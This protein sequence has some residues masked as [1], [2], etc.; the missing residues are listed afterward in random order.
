MKTL[1]TFVV[2]L[3]ATASAHAFT[4]M[5]TN[6]YGTNI[7]ATTIALNGLASKIQSMEQSRYFYQGKIDTLEHQVNRMETTMLILVCLFVI[8]AVAYCMLKARD[9]VRAV[10]A[11]DVVA[12]R[13]TPDDAEK[14]KE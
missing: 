10:R 3:L 6:T 5:P 2:L 12:R 8:V 14:K 9:Q 4:L 1:I 13:Q 7:D 11:N